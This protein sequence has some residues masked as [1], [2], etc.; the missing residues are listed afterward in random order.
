MTNA[1]NW[2]ESIISNAMT[3]EPYHINVLVNSSHDGLEFFSRLKSTSVSLANPTPSYVVP[4]SLNTKA[5]MNDLY[6]V[7]YL[8]FLQK[9]TTL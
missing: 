8:I 7:T 9:G 5:T 3:P 1:N 2:I 6:N 4:F